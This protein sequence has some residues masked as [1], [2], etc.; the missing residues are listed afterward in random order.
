MADSLSSAESTGISLNM[1]FNPLN[2]GTYCVADTCAVWN[3][4]SSKTLWLTSIGAK[5][6]VCIPQYVMYECRSK[7][8]T[9]KP[10]AKREAERELSARLDDALRQDRIPI[11]P[12]ELDDLLE[13]EVLEKRKKLGKGELAAMVLAK[14]TRQAFLTDDQEARE[15]AGATYIDMQVQTTPHLLG[16]LVFHSHLTVAQVDAVVIEHEELGGNLKPYFR[17]VHFLALG[18]RDM[19]ER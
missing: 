1:S 3:L 17:E 4:L 11:Y 16:F 7:R 10:A 12:I 2:F 6:F 5:F 14:K 13:I 8:R 9:D 15:I 19:S 18:Y